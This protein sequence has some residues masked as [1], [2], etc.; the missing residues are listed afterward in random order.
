MKVTNTIYYENQ[1]FEDYLEMPGT[2]FS[3]TKEVVITPTEGMKLGTRVHNYLNEPKEYDWHDAERVIPIAT[4]L[5]ATIGDAF[6]HLKKEVGFTSNFTHNGMTLKYKGRAD[7]LYVGKVVIDIKVLAG[8]IDTAIVRYGYDKQ[9]SGYCLATGA[10]FGLIISWNKMSKKVE[11][12]MILPS[13]A[14]WKYQCAHRG[15]PT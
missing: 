5:R 4:A 8:S 2:S 1:K 3:S 10:N 6:F 13:D 11:K 7:M 12:K 9:I 14:F 15:F